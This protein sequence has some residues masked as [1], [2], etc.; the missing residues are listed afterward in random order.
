MNRA[1]ARPRVI[2]CLPAWNA[3]AFIEPVLQSLDA[4]TYPNLQVLVS[5]DASTD[6]TG[7]ICEAFARGRPRFVVHRQVVN[8]GWIGNVNWMLR[9]AD[10]VYLFFAFH[11]DPL[12][13]RY[14]ERL[15]EA[16]EAAP[17]AVLAF[18]D[19]TIDLRSAE[20]DLVSQWCFTDLD[21]VGSARERLRVM[22]RM[23]GHWWIPNRGLFRQS[24]A[25]RVGGLRR[26]LAG[27]HAA[28]WPWLLH[29]C[30]LG[31][32]VRVPEPLVR[33]VWRD[34]GLSKSWRWNPATRFAVTLAAGREIVRADL[35]LALRARLAADFW[36]HWLGKWW[37]EKGKWVAGRPGDR[38]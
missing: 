8:R 4:Q 37:R 24:A 15:V 21:G 12:E 33:K 23:E 32:F 14:V 16:L 13:P 18:T 20:L 9:E 30:L 6:T 29:L 31:R 38:L 3:A 7:A 10:G 35:P 2:A 25:R 17:D 11:D 36:G 34:G 28:D 26:H 5:D 19:I 27:E 22:T 1:S